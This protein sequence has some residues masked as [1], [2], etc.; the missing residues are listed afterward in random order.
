MT[1]AYEQ[2]ASRRGA[3]QQRCVIA[4]MKFAVYIIN[5]AGN[6]ANHANRLLW[7]NDAIV[8]PDGYAAKVTAHV[9]GNQTFL[10]NDLGITDSALQGIVETAINTYS[11]APGT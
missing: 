11:I 9:M 1:L 7:A 3:I 5:E 8:S 6:T 4:V 10:D 2:L